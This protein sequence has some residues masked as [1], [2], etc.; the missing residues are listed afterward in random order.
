MPHS[1]ASIPTNEQFDGEVAAFVKDARTGDN[2]FT[3]VRGQ[4]EEDVGPVY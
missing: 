4:D 1:A 3:W 2:M